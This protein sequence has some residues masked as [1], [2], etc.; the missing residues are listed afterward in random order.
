MKNEH[1]E[2]SVTRRNLLT[3]LASLTASLAGLAGLAQGAKSP[4]AKSPATTKAVKW[5]DKYEVAVDFEILQADGFRYHR[6]YVAVWLEDSMGKSV[7]TLSLWVQTSRRG[8]R[9]I[10]DLRRWYAEDQERL[11]TPG[12]ADL[13]MTVSSATRMPGKYSLTWDGRDD[14]QKPVDQGTY[15]LNIESAREHGPYQLIR[16]E[17]VIN[18]AKPFKLDLEG[19]SEIK[20]A[21]VEYRKRK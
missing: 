3:G 6:P 11:R 21:S 8:P 2:K 13:V 7:R 10:P 12:A 1:A 4:V 15:T 5:D 20:G 19:N 9:W 18:S 17:I 16:K 14:K